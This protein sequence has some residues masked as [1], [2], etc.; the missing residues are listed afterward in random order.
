MFLKTSLYLNYFLKST[1]N[2]IIYLL[3]NKVN[4]NM[5][6]LVNVLKTFIKYNGLA[7]ISLRCAAIREGCGVI[8]THLRRSGENLQTARK[9]KVK[10][11]V[12]K[13][14]LTRRTSTTF[15]W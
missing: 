13:R 15:A 2:S 4:Y 8:N 3:N 12:E 1:Y 11:G 14:E 9:L 6:R 10:K 7:E 5:N